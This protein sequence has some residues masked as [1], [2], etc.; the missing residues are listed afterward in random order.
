M[1]RTAKYLRRSWM[2]LKLVF[3]CNDPKY[4]YPNPNPAHYLLA[5]VIALLALFA[6]F[7]KTQMSKIISHHPDEWEAVVE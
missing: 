4:S 1:W 7:S 2:R 6:S 5:L 3:F